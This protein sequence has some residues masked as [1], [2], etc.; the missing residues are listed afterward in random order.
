VDEDPTAR[1]SPSVDLALKLA[2][3]RSIRQDM[4]AQL[5]RSL[6]AGAAVFP[7]LIPVLLKRRFRSE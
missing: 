2:T 7:A 5:A 6:R 3:G 1:R 4:L